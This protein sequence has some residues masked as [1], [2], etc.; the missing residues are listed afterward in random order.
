[1]RL[2]VSD[3]VACKCFIGLVVLSGSFFLSTC[4]F[5][6]EM[7]RRK[8]RLSV[9]RK[10]EERKKYAVVSLPI[11][12]DLSLVRVLEVSIPR[13][14]VSTPSLNI[15]L[16]LHSFTAG[17]P[18]SIGCLHDRLLKVELPSHWSTS[19]SL[20]FEQL[21]LCKLQ[22]QQPVS[23]TFSLT[24]NSL[25]RWDL[26][27]THH[28]VTEV[29]DGVLADS[30]PSLRTVDHVLHLLSMLDAVKICTGNP[31]EQFLEAA[32]DRAEHNSSGELLVV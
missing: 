30:P 6:S 18:P 31:E 15:S 26:W 27:F 13:H 24:I 16:P 17:S 23:V 19:S 8:F 14:L 32:S 21:T 12:I 5:C 3:C 29:R 28:N 20:A 9:H 11:S 10:N 25:F 22:H 1:M 4:S 2:N 7:G